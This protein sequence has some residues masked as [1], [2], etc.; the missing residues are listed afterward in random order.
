MSE[1]AIKRR[2]RYAKES[3][4]KELKQLHHTITNSD[5]EIICFTATFG[6]F[7]ERKIRVIVDKITDNDIELIKKYN[8]ISNQT[9]EIWCKKEDGFECKIFDKDNNLLDHL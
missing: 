3:A 6:S 9:K 5:N 8:I 2:I 4:K 7:L 1:E